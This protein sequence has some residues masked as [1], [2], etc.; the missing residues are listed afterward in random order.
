MVKRDWTA[1]RQKE[2]KDAAYAK[3]RERYAVTVEKT[4]AGRNRIDGH[5]AAVLKQ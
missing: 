3:I 1:E 5:A 2:L 4:N